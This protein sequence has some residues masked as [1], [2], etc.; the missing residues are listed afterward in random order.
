MPTQVL[1]V[2]GAV[3]TLTRDLSKQSHRALF[4]STNQGDL[5]QKVAWQ[6]LK[7]HRIHLSHRDIFRPAPH[8]PLLGCPRRMHKDI[9]SCKDG[10]CLET[11]ES[12]THCQTR[13]RC[14]SDLSTLINQESDFYALNPAPLISL[15]PRHE[16]SSEL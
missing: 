5:C 16:E 12:T 1:S 3:H 7:L 8:F 11:T 13:P 10:C 14:Y 6:Q 9:Y 2:G 15:S 4:S